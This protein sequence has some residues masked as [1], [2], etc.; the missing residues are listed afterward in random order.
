MG[1]GE[2]SWAMKK[3]LGQ[4]D[5]D[6]FEKGLDHVMENHISPHLH[7]VRDRA[8]ESE[9]PEEIRRILEEEM[10]EEER[11]ELF[12]DTWGEVIA[13]FIHLRIDPFEGFLNLKHLLRDPYT[14]E[15]MLLMFDVE[16]TPKDIVEANKDM[17]AT[18]VK[19]IG[20][21]L[22]PEMYGRDDVEQ[23]VELVGGDPELL[24]IHD[25]DDYETE[26]E[27]GEL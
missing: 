26:P 16:G 5:K 24:D 18:Y 6:S 11:N 4:I 8:S 13:S 25:E 23:V 1:D 3:V 15:A 20:V 9:D 12:H 19:C 14:L 10:T 2:L 22:A 7:D 21:A 27:S 17:A